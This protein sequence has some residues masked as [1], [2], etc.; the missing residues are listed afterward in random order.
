MHKTAPFL[1]SWPPAPPA[2]AACCSK[3]MATTWPGPLSRVDA[4]VASPA[5]P[6]AAQTP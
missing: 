4:P 1:A 6:R 5:K 2:R 3:G